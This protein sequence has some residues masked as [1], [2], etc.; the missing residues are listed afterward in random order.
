MLKYVNLKKIISEFSYLGQQEKVLKNMDGI[1]S[2][3][4]P[5][6]SHYC[7]EHLA[8]YGNFVTCILQY[9]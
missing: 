4:M 3:Y 5:Y 7:M 1:Y 9:S 6:I 2:E 8:V